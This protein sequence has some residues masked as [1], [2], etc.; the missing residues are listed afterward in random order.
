M[1]WGTV[2]ACVLGLAGAVFGTDHLRDLL[3]SGRQAL[4]D[5][6]SRFVDDGV[7]LQREVAT[8][9]REL[10]KVVASLRMA[11]KDSERELTQ[12]GAAVLELRQGIELIDRDLRVLASAVRDGRGVV[13]RGHDLAADPAQRMAARLLRTRESYNARIAAREQLMAR[14]KANRERI[15][16]RLDEA[17]LELRTFNESARDVQA[18]LALVKAGE[19]V[20]ELQ[21]HI[22]P[23]SSFDPSGL[24]R[25]SRRLDQR[26]IEQ[27][28]REKLRRGRVTEDPVIRRVR[29]QGVTAELNRLFPRDAP[30][31]PEGE[32]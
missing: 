31:N 30:T 15:A 6:T 32:R 1:R 24:D 11:L 3:S 9:Q 19:R 20:A 16:A 23:A 7:V 28:E 18:Q 17:E 22:G 12:Q 26:L 4:K 21:R 10:P 5:E 27:E 14:L 13:L 25:L 8:A 2:G 29:D